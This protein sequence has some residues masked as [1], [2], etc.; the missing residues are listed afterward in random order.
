MEII[1][2]SLLQKD[3]IELGNIKQ[4]INTFNHL[5]SKELILDS[6]MVHYIFKLIKIIMNY[7]EDYYVLF[8]NKD[9]INRINYELKK[10]E[11][12]KTYENTFK[13]IDSF[14]LQ[15]YQYWFDNHTFSKGYS[16]VMDN[17]HN[18]WHLINLVGKRLS[19]FGD[20]DPYKF[21][22]KKITLDETIKLGQNFFDRHK[23]PIDI[24]KLKN[25]RALIIDEDEKIDSFYDG[26]ILGYTYYD[27]NNNKRSRVLYQQ[28][29]LDG[30]GI[31][32][33][34]MH[35]YNLPSQ[36]QN[37]T[38]QVL[39]EVIAYVCEFIYVYELDE[40]YNLDK[41]K[42]FWDMK[43]YIYNLCCNS[44]HIYKLLLL[45]SVKK[46]ITEK[47]YNN[48]FKDNNFDSTIKCFESFCS[49]WEKYNI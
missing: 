15:E 21:D 29:F 39:T 37:F 40:E 42:F 5:A 17:I 18:F 4:V 36:K 31:V 8:R 44:Y 6:H 32:H 2:K 49:L 1:D 34:L 24:K 47:S 23:I 26:K 33:E 48:L 13:K 35:Y 25:K 41:N 20:I 43:T 30:V 46:S 45:Y 10:D 11:G 38:S 28:N 19:V 16:F 14:C 22:Y 7:S 12:Y 27:K 3:D 9:F